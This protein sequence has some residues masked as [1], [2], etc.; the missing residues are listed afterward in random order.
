MISGMYLG[1]IVRRVIMRMSQEAEIFGD[2]LPKL[3]T[4]FILSLSLSL[5]LTHTHTHTQQRMQT[6]EICICVAHMRLLLCC[7]FNPAA[8]W[9]LILYKDAGLAS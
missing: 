7:A 4:P 5:S 2:I 9:L 1:D 3:P 8:C 6:Q